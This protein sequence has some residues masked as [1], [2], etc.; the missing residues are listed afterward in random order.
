NRIDF[1][2]AAFGQLQL[3]LEAEELGTMVTIRL[4]EAI[5]TDGTIN[6]KPGAR[7]RYAEYE[8]PLRRGRHTYRIHFRPDKQN[9][10]PRAIKMPE[11]IGEVMPFRYVE[12]EGYK[13]EIKKSI[14]TRITVHYPFDNFASHFES[15]D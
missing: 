13:G 11:Y 4:G 15:S 10:G 5:N 7:V 1:G 2:K 8:I 14:V 12:I 3:T 6:R 9:T